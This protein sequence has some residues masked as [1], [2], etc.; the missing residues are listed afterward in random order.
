[1]SARRDGATRSPSGLSDV[2]P[3]T[4]N[5]IAVRKYVHAMADSQAFTLLSDALYDVSS[6]FLHVLA[7]WPLLRRGDP[8]SGSACDSVLFLELTFIARTRRSFRR[9]SG[10]ERVFFAQATS[11]PSTLPRPARATAHSFL[12]LPRLS[13]CRHTHCSAPYRS[14]CQPRPNNTLRHHH[15]SPRRTRIMSSPASRNT[16]AHP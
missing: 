8:C 16:T 1:M 11:K 2:T 3:T 10:K 14:C 5:G 4:T 7:D 13:L 6:H 15:A 9:R 12:C